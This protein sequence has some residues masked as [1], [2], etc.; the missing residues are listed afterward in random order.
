MRALIY[1]YDP[2]A[3]NTRREKSNTAAD[4]VASR[5]RAKEVATKESE[6]IYS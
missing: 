4:R 1:K 3:V 6:K 5:A 2:L